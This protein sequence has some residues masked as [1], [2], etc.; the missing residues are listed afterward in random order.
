MGNEE[1]KGHSKLKQQLKPQC[2]QESS[3]PVEAMGSLQGHEQSCALGGDLGGCAQADVR[4]RCRV[5]N[6]DGAARGQCK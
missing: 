2:K 5:G 1:Q 6:R 4:A 3:G